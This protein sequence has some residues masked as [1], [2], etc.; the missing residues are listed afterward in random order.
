[1]NA[2]ALPASLTDVRTAKDARADTMFRLTLTGAGSD[3]TST[4]AL[5]NPST[6]F[7]ATTGG[8]GFTTPTSGNITMTMNLNA[9]KSAEIYK[10][11]AGTDIYITATAT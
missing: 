2:T 10:S 1:M 6:N 11:S 8:I 3:T 7:T 9:A 4:I 5:S